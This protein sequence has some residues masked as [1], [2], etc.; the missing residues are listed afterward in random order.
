MDYRPDSIK[1]VKN[2]PKVN[3]KEPF[4]PKMT[5]IYIPFPDSSQ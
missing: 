4:S 2:K 3:T 1:L 5:Y